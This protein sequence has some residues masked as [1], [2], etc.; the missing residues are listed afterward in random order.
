[1]PVTLQLIHCVA[2][3]ALLLSSCMCKIVIGQ[4]EMNDLQ[5]GCVCI[6]KDTAL[7]GLSQP[8]SPA[9]KLQMH[10]QLALLLVYLGGKPT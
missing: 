8:Q 10:K 4:T 7:S 9:E 6:Q 5:H 3:A 2:V 1:M